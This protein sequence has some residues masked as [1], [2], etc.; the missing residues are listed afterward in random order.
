MAHIPVASP[1]NRSQF[2]PPARLRHSAESRQRGW[3]VDARFFHEGPKSL[4]A[5]R[6]PTQKVPPFAL[7]SG[8]ETGSWWAAI[9]P[10]LLHSLNAGSQD[11]DRP[12]AGA[13]E[14]GDQTGAPKMNTTRTRNETPD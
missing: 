3:D 8:R 7:T 14:N 9:A 5:S 6:S 2:Y 11:C 13:R 10:L 12:S 1:A 4:S